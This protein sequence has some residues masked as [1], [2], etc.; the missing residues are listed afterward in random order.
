MIIQL[1]QGVGTERRTGAET[2]AP[3]ADS[4]QRKAGQVALCSADRGA[5][6]RGEE[7]QSWGLHTLVHMYIFH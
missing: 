7:T 2:L 3:S 1:W 4:W 5:G 6:S